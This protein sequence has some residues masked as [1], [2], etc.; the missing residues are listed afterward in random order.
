MTSNR[1][2]ATVFGLVSLL[3]LGCSAWV[4]RSVVLSGP[5]VESGA[6]P[7]TLTLSAG[8]F[9]DQT[10]VQP[11]CQ[12]SRFSFRLT[13]GRSRRGTLQVS[14]F[15]VSP[16][17]TWSADPV[18]LET[19]ALSGATDTVDLAF[20]PIAGGWEQV[21]GAR[22]RLMEGDEATVPLLVNPRSSYEGGT[23]IYR[24]RPSPGDLVF[25]AGPA[26]ES[27]SAVLRCALSEKPAWLQHPALIV[28]LL[29]TFSMAVGACTAV[30]F[31]P[32][33]GR[34]AVWVL[35]LTI[36]VSTAGLWL[37]GTPHF[38]APDEPHHYDYAR[39][40]A[41][42]GKLPDTVPK[43]PNEWETLDWYNDQWIQP[44][45][46][47]MA[48]SPIVIAAGARTSGA[49]WTASARSIWRGTGP[50]GAIYD[51]PGPPTAQLSRVMSW[52]RALGLVF[53][54]V[55]LLLLY[56]LL[57]GPIG[58][59]PAALACAG[60]ATVPQ[61][62][63]LAP[64]ISNDFLATLLATSAFVL[65]AVP[66]SLRT[67]RWVAIGL[68]SGAAVAT[69]LTALWVVP[70]LGVALLLEC[71][72]SRVGAS[73]HAGVCAAGLMVAGGWV[74]LRNY[75][76]WGDILARNFQVAIQ[77]PY[78][79]LVE[80]NAWEV[81]VAARDSLS[82]LYS[83]FWANLGW[84]TVRPDAGSWVWKLYAFFT[85]MVGALMVGLLVRVARRRVPPEV[86]RLALVALA[87]VCSWALLYVV[88]YMGFSLNPLG[89]GRHAY[90]AVA[91]AM[92]LTGLA[93]RSQLDRRDRVW[94]LLVA[95]ILGASCLV[96]LASAWLVVFRVGLLK[97]HFL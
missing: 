6:E 66:S 48:M 42:H 60:L 36:F 27:S 93:A 38:E 70:M 71:R 51:H 10:F 18:V 68:L 40:V 30:S 74:F 82:I 29:F 47:Y 52:L 39:W 65:V 37:L 92:L 85:T 59:V 84:L 13:S 91:P 41:S 32:G 44:P 35:P 77:A 17:N 61:F 24:G 97:F 45:L 79:H 55:V 16:T 43:N 34:L 26:A 58:R 67:S 3:L 73:R 62:T 28:L 95:Q 14:L 11:T 15:R 8:Q 50:Q 94:A 22:V 69:K 49:L 81:L 1:V 12:L 87:G 57:V 63:F 78:Y 88:S 2:A 7:S 64:T 56:R 9:V 23:L 89:Q 5:A 76:L 72:E 46:Y 19:V 90:P 86:G 21:F 83:S 80:R 31:V 96:A 54:A 20:E 53:G 75:W 4:L 33:R 25:R